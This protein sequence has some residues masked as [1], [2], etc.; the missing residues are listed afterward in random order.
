MEQTGKLLSSLKIG[1]A[2]ENAK[3]EEDYEDDFEDTTDNDES[4]EVDEEISSFEHDYSDESFE[5]DDG[6]DEE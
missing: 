2:G 3:Q 5:D 1:K 4:N 6:S